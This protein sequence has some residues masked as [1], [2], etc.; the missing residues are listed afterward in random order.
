V[1][2]LSS[3]SGSQAIPYSFVQQKSLVCLSQTSLWQRGSLLL[4]GAFLFVF[5]LLFPPK[6]Q[7]S[8][9]GGRSSKSIGHHPNH[10]RNPFSFSGSLNLAL[11]FPT[12]LSFTVYSDEGTTGRGSVKAIHCAKSTMP[13][14]MLAKLFFAPCTSA[15]E[16]LCLPSHVHDGLLSILWEPSKGGATAPS[17]FSPPNTVPSPA[18]P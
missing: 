1:F 10:G 4:S 9:F 14:S 13:S 8:H 2:C 12:S 7:P 18:H 11:L 15:F 16:S 3:A 6:T 17:S 5:F